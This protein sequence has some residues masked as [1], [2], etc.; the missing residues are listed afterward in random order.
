MRFEPPMYPFLIIAH[1]ST[2]PCELDSK[3]GEKIKGE[4]KD[5]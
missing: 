4:E 5:R 3:L 1:P 2:T